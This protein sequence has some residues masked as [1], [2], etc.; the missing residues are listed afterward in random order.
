MKRPLMSHLKTKSTSSSS[1]FD[2]YNASTSQIRTQ[3][4]PASTIQVQQALQDSYQAQKHW[5]NDFTPT[6]RSQVFLKASQLMSEKSQ[7]LTQ[8]E[9]NDTSKPISQIKSYD[10]PTAIETLSYYAYMPSILP[11]GSTL[12]HLDAHHSF[13]YTHRIPL[14]LTIGIG[15]WNYPLLN[16]VM[17]SAPSLIFGNSMIYKPSELTPSSALFLAELYEE[18]GLPKG[19]F[20][21]VLGKGK[22][23]GKTLIDEYC[24]TSINH[25]TEGKISFTGSVDAGHDIAAQTAS[26]CTTTPTTNNRINRMHNANFHRLNLELGGKSPL[27]IMEDCDIDNAVS[28]AIQANFYANGQVCSNGTRVYVHESINE[29]FITKLV[30]ETCKLKIGLPSQVDVD[31]GP[32]V[33]KEHMEKVVEYI[34]IGKNDDGATL[35]HGGEKV[36]SSIDGHHDGYFLSPAIFVNCTDDM[37][38]VQEEVFGMLM[39]VLTFEDDEEVIG[40]ANATNFGLAAGIVTNNVKKAHRMASRLNTGTVWINQYNTSHVSVPWGGMKQSGIGRENGTAALEA[41]TTEKVVFMD[42]E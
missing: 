23:V 14:G 13:A 16:A 19:V 1:C 29:S 25:N 10:V 40:R 11:S 9:L 36:S 4:Q 12:H 5:Y 22:D 35:V 42:M 30:Q 26:S 37:R 7:Q 20:Q 21:V 15:A 27:I 38:I 8:L 2:L 31:I 3:V 34:Q 6:Q 39:S 24:S 17:K 18:C 33:S 41:W 32:M 28:I